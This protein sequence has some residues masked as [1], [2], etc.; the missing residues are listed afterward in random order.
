MIMMSEVRMTRIWSVQ[1]RDPFG[2][3]QTG[4]CHVWPSC[5]RSDSHTQS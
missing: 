1:F 5:G 4:H 2:G 3:T